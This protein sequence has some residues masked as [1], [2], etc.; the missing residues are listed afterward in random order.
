LGL[1]NHVRLNNSEKLKEVSG[2]GGG[3]VDYDHPIMAC[4]TTPWNMETCGGIFS[5]ESE[6]GGRYMFALRGEQDVVVKSIG[7]YCGSSYYYENPVCDD[8]W[9][10]DP[11][12]NGEVYCGVDF[13]SA[14]DN[15]S[16]VDAEQDD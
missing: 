16:G 5:E 8:F 11:N 10:K 7:A 9:E 3:F 12:W 2:T 14:P 13:C 4:T 1:T 6:Q 15:D